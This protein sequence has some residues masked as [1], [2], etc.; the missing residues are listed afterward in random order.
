MDTR[1]APCR[2]QGL[3]RSMPYRAKPTIPRPITSVK[4][5]MPRNSGYSRR[6]PV[7]ARWANDQWRWP[8]KATVIATTVARPLAAT[9]PVPMWP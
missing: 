9:A 4:P 5:L 3:V 2:A 6:N 8:K 7:R 1:L